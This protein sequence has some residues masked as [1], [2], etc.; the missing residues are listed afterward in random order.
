[1]LSIRID[2]NLSSR[3]LRLISACCCI[4]IFS[5]SLIPD[6]V[7]GRDGVLYVVTAEVFSTQGF[8]A[9]YA[10]F[11][12]PFYPIIIGTLQQ[13]IPISFET[14]AHL[15]N[16]CLYTLLVDSFIRCYWQWQPYA[17]YK[18]LP[19]V[20][21]LSYTGINDY[22]PEIFRDWGFWAFCWLSFYYFLKAYQNT[23][24][25]DFLGWQFAIIIAFLFRIE[26]VAF[27]LALPF[28]FL[29]I[30]K[31]PL[32]FFRSINLFVLILFVTALFIFFANI[33]LLKGAGA[34][35]L[36]VISQYI[37]LPQVIAEFVDS[38]YKIAKN[39]MP[40]HYKSHAIS[41]VLSGLLGVVF[42]KSLVKLGY[43][44]LAI[45]L[46]GVCMKLPKAE[47]SKFP[48]Y[49]LFIS[50]LI[51]FLYFCKSKI[52]T[53]RYV[54]QTILVLLLFVCY[55]MEII[56]NKLSKIDFVIFPIIITSLFVINLLFGL[57][58][59]ASS[60]QHFKEMGG[61]IKNNLKPTESIISNSIRLY[62]YSG[63]YSSNYTGKKTFAKVLT[64]LSFDQYKSYSYLL[65]YTKDDPDVPPPKRTIKVHSI[66][67]K[68]GGS[69]I[70]YKIDH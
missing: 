59:T 52:I 9:T 3:N 15:I 5:I 14:S 34:E 38:S 8:A 23:D 17:Q 6:G 4:I 21:I 27:M 32:L 40:Y 13:I 12:W 33:D 16:I 36:R 2:S 31:S 49:L 22:Q 19:A 51:V 47:Q 53:G 11:S 42:L 50:F 29:F 41:F 60:K 68:K 1:M 57:I 56:I 25:R 37:N 61:W 58:H 55:Y 24:V 35:R 66:T 69:S 65:I 7:L 48:A 46:Y 45:L 26:A 54:I 20:I 62:Y 28:I 63:R 39:A 70:L 64:D 67:H 10:K 30:K 44:Y 43:F 18:W